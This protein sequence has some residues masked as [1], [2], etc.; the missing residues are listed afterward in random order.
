LPDKYAESRRFIGSKYF[1]GFLVAHIAQ[2]VDTQFALLAEANFV[3][4]VHIFPTNT[5]RSFDGDTLN[6]SIFE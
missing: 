2:V 6:D 1:C 4:A 3:I 5:T